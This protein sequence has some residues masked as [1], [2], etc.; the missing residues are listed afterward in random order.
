MIVL[1]V[2]GE[3]LRCSYA[4]E[5]LQLPSG[6]TEV[7]CPPFEQTCPD[8]LCPANCAGRGICDFSLSP[9]MCECFDRNDTSPFCSESPSSFAPTVSPAPTQKS[10][11]SST[12][13]TGEPTGLPSSTT[14]TAALT[15]EVYSSSAPTS[16]TIFPVDLPASPTKSSADGGSPF[17]PNDPVSATPNTLQSNDFVSASPTNTSL[18]SPTAAPG[19]D[20]LTDAPVLQRLAAKVD[21]IFVTSA[22]ASGSLQPG[23]AIALC[24]VVTGTWWLVN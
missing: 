19:T 5:K 12:A 17:Q 21:P 4:G 9:P 18:D 2:E 23:S 8:S 10:V 15:G 24:F 16:P 1:V 20:S 14:P 6:G 13:P 3:S 7:T 22:P 11:V